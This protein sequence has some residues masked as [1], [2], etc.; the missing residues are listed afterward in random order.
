MFR[1]IIL[2]KKYWISVLLLGLVFI[3]LFSIT[4]HLMQYG[5]IAFDAFVEDKINNG[6]WV[7]YLISRII[8]GLVYGMILGYYFEV[9]KQKQKQ[10]P[11]Q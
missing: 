3:V 11:N 8:G 5:G 9:R 4:E 2:S 6:R 10:K 1:A 7:R